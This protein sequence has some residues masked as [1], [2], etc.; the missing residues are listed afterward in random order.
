MI[1]FITIHSQIHSFPGYHIELYDILIDGKELFRVIFDT[2]TNASLLTLW[3]G[4]VT[5]VRSCD[6][7]KVM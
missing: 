2:V 7:G 4:H 3:S 5:V 1:T 6:C